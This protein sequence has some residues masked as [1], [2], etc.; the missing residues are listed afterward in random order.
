MANYALL[1]ENNVVTNIIT[2]IDE[3]EA[4]P[5]GFAD[6][7]AF[8]S[9][10]HNCT[11]K[12]TSRNTVANTHLEGN[13]PFRCNYATIGGTYDSTNDVFIGPQP[14]ASFTLDENYIYQPPIAHPTDGNAYKWNEEAYQADNSQGWELIE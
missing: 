7:E 11:V 6:W 13:T 5:E 8:Y 10:F 12:R 1:D 2:G 14:H 4:A 3:T 9:D